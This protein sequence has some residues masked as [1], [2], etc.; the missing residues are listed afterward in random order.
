MGIVFKL[1]RHL[2]TFCPSLYLVLCFTEL[3]PPHIPMFYMYACRGRDVCAS[4][5]LDFYETKVCAVRTETPRDIV[6]T[7]L[8][9][10]LLRFM[11][12]HVC[13]IVT[14]QHC[15]VRHLIW[16]NTRAA[17]KFFASFVRNLS[18]DSVAL[19]P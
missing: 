4:L 14:L 1:E 2:I 7:D 8:R 9:I 19:S 13:L 16:D 11:F 15:F 12:A 17:A 6:I 10:C 5:L 18:E 3:S